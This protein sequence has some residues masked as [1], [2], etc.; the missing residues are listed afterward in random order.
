MP[1]PSRI[2]NAPTLMDGLEIYQLAFNL[3]TTSRQLSQG[4]I[5]PIPYAAISNFCREEEITGELRDDVF[6][7]V[8][9]LD[10]AYLKHT[11]KKDDKE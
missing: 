5:G 7:H 2:Q 6:Y 3:L 9:R 1:L 10:N 4:C 8:E 11:A